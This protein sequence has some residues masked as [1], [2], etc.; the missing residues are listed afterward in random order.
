M[1]RVARTIAD[2]DRPKD[3]GAG[4]HDDI[5]AKAAKDGY[6]KVRIDGTYYDAREKRRLRRYV[7]HD[8][9]DDPELE[10]YRRALDLMPSLEEARAGLER[11]RGA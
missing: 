8:L 9:S 4:T 7:E 3:L 10:A 11:V 6:L 1:L 2:L 5:I